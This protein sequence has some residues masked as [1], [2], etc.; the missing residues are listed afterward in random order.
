ML[1]PIRPAARPV[2]A[3]LAG[4][5]LIG[6][7]AAC[8]PA[9]TD[10]LPVTSD[11]GT[12]EETAAAES[13]DSTES[14]AASATDYENGTYEAEGGYQSPGGNEAILVSLTVEGDVV[15]AVTVTPEATSGNAAQYQKAFASG[16]GAE[17][18]GQDIDSLNVTKVAGSSLTSGGFNAALET[19][20]AD[21]A[22]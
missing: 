2:L 20:K 15:T 21:A 5:G 17:V 12:G 16:I 22:A 3:L 4:L 18:V 7:L 13:S 14:D 11:A 10:S 9:E 8:A 1:D 6:G 19:I